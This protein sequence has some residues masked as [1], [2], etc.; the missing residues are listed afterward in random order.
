MKPLV[1]IFVFLFPLHL[2]LPCEPF[3]AKTIL[4]KDESSK[5]SS[6]VLFKTQ[7]LKA[8]KTKDEVFLLNTIDPK[9]QFSFGADSGKNN[10]IQNFELDKKPKDSPVWKILDS[11]L[12]L[13][14]FLN[15]EGNFVS[16]FLFENFPEDLD[17]T[18]YS[19]V[20]GKNVNVREK[21]NISSKVLNKLSYTVVGLDYT[22]EYPSSGDCQ[23]QKVCLADGTTGFIC[24]TYL[25][26]PL[27][28]R[29]FF[30]KKK[31]KWMITTFI[32]G[33]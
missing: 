10:F 5:D 21:P 6:F 4:P 25:R 12:K 16:P 13:G 18:A 14:Y 22:T 23:W 19:L 28:Y 29:I 11:T 2:I 30:E 26:S 24:D 15:R 1:L 3:R 9:I 7:L 20:S 31:Q 27:D 8:I 33:D 32:A 17:P